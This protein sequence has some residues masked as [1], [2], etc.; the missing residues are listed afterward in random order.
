MRGA[1]EISSTPY[2]YNENLIL[3]FRKKRPGFSAL[4]NQSSEQNSQLGVECEQ[5]WEPAYGTK[6]DLIGSGER[7]ENILRTKIILISDPKL[8]S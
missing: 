8:L 3:P 7:Q 1:T 6:T 5:L 2:L 4:P